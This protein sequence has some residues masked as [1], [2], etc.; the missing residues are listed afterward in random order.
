MKGFVYLCK[1]L[2][3]HVGVDLGC[4]NR[5]VAQERLHCAQISA[6]AQEIGAKRVPERVRSYFFGDSGNARVVLDNSFDRSGRQR[7]FFCL[8]V[9]LFFCF[10]RCLVVPHKQIGRYIV[11][12]VQI[13][14]KGIFCGGG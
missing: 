10:L 3:R 4:G 9:L 1:V 14:F 2:I 5:R 8:L 11:A 6:A 7:L 13:V 12:S